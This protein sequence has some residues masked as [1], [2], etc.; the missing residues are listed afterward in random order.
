MPELKIINNYLVGN[1]ETTMF[2][3]TQLDT[4]PLKVV[5]HVA[6]SPVMSGC[7]K[8]KPT[9]SVKLGLSCAKLSRSCNW[10]V[11]LA[12]LCLTTK[13]QDI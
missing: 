8:T 12:Y 1:T 7:C 10:Y 5:T 13:L 2:L 4:D 9:W 6:T 3:Q 11:G